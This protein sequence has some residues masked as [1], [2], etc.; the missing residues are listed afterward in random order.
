[1]KLGRTCAAVAVLAATTLPLTAAV[2]WADESAQPSRPAPTE[3][4]EESA[5]PVPTEP[6]ADAGAPTGEPTATRAE[7]APSEA[8]P[9]PEGQVSQRPEGAPETGGGPGQGTAAAAIGGAAA[10]VAVAGGGTVLVLRRKRA[11]TH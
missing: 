6:P 4:A 11:G 10:V 2:G 5:R 7:Q 1:M 3:E 8:R 9:V